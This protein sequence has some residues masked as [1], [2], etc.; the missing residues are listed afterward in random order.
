MWGLNRSKNYIS[1]VHSI[2]TDDSK[3]YEQLAQENNCWV[4]FSPSLEAG[5]IEVTIFTHIPHR[6]NIEFTN[7]LYKKQTLQIKQPSVKKRTKKA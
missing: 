3:I 1:F 2:P 5:K 7:L 4:S 6:F